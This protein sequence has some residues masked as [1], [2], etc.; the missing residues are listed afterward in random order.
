ME[1]KIKHEQA[2]NISVFILSSRPID[3][4]ISF[5]P[6]AVFKHHSGKRLA[7]YQIDQILCNIK[8]PDIIICGGFEATKISRDGFRV[9]EN[10]N[11]QTTSICEDIRI[12]MSLA[13]YKNILFIDAAT[14][15]SSNIFSSFDK[16]YTIV[17]GEP[18]DLSVVENNGKLSNIAHD[19]SNLYWK[20]ILYVSKYNRKELFDLVQVERQWTF[21]ELVNEVNKRINIE[22]RKSTGLSKINNSKTFRE[23][24]FRQ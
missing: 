7:Q 3:R 21:F 6:P 24:G 5:G 11:W 19:V 12:C 10:S 2:E 23:L 18:E 17:S 13:K 14:H 22:I 20:D 15:F 8:N 4:M 1:F 9:V 16:S